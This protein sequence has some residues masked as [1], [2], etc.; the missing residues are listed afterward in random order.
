M[1]DY[2]ALFSFFKWKKTWK[3]LRY[4]LMIDPKLNK[5]FFRLFDDEGRIISSYFRITNKNNS[6]NNFFYNPF[7][8]STYTFFFL[9]NYFKKKN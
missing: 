7:S 4:N 9:K 1:E 5:N 6:N 3:E 2:E 8:Y